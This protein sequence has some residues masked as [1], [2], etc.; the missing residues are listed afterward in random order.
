ME[1]PPPDFQSATSG[2]NHGA[3]LVDRQQV[4]ADPSGG[5]RTY[6]DSY[7]DDPDVMSSLT[8]IFDDEVRQ[9]SLSLHEQQ[10]TCM[11]LCRVPTPDPYRTAGSA[12][13]MGFLA[14]FVSVRTVSTQESPS[15]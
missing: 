13:P 1:S 14:H 10:L 4:I 3:A 8:E 9:K 5:E 7:A 15:R 6:A 2:G 11:Y 12:R